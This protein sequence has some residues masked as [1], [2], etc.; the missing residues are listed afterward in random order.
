[1]L[2]CISGRRVIR[3]AGIAKPAVARAF[4]RFAS[5]ALP[6]QASVQLAQYGVVCHRLRQRRCAWLG[7]RRHSLR[8]AS[9]L[10]STDICRP[11]S[12]IRC[13]LSANSDPGQKPG[14]EL[15]RYFTGKEVPTR[16]HTRPSGLSYFR[17][18]VPLRAVS[19]WR[20]RDF[21]T[22]ASCPIR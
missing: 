5:R 3:A 1:M 10:K 22:P 4:R 21:N 18:Q 2:G 12:D 9:A 15:L 16:A 20:R 13:F 17:G 7:L 6:E 8:F 11:N 14:F 19:G